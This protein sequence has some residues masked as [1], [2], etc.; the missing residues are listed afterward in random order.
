MTRVD[1][2][3][4]I[5]FKAPDTKEN[6]TVESIT[7]KHKGQ[8]IIIDEWGTVLSYQKNF[9]QETES[10]QVNRPVIVFD[11]MYAPSDEKKTD[12]EKFQEKY[13]KLFEGYTVVYIDSSKQNIM[14]NNQVSNLP[15]Y[16]L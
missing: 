12:W 9:T 15:I 8:K 4:A 13:D 5:Y 14:T 16:K 7:L 3:G 1:I 10:F 11:I 2:E 6:L